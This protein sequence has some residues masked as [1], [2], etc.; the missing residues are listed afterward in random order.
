VI[1]HTYW[2]VFFCF[3]GILGGLSWLE[4]NK[5]FDRYVFL[6]RGEPAGG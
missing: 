4:L 3:F 1:L 6:T 2:Q 5:R